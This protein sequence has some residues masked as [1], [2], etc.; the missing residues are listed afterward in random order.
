M[1]SYFLC[2][3]F[4]NNHCCWLLLYIC[5]PS[6]L[7]YATAT[8]RY[9]YDQQAMYMYMYPSNKQYYGITLPATNAVAVYFAI[10]TLLLQCNSSITGR[11]LEWE[12][13][14]LLTLYDISYLVGQ[15]S[16]WGVIMALLTRVHSPFFSL[17]SWKLEI[18]V[19]LAS[20]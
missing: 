11:H 2:D 7:V 12:I 14:S 17:F 18:Q 15:C 3:Q 10:N 19:N 8:K 4:R 6:S 13:L 20:L 5:W 9:C 16:R 1:P